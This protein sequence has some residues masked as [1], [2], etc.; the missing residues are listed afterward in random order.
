MLILEFS[1]VSDQNREELLELLL[2]VNKVL[3]KRLDDMYDK[4]ARDPG[5]VVSLGGA[6]MLH[7]SDS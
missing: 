2:Q 6:L 7:G 1:R 3:T 4:M 5:L